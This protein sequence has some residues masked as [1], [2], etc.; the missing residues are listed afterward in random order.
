MHINSFPQS[1]DEMH[2]N[3]LS[4]HTLTLCKVAQLQLTALGSCHCVQHTA[5]G[6]SRV[7]EDW[8]HSWEDRNTHSNREG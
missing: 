1:E 4:I 5:L 7:G 8:Q 3:K 6:L 2:Q